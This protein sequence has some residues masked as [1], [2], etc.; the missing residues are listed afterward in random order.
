MTA[1]QPARAVWI[2]ITTSINPLSWIMRHSLRGLCGLKLPYRRR[3]KPLDSSQP[4]RAVWIEIIVSPVS[5]SSPLS[6]P[7]RA[8]WIEIAMLSCWTAGKV[9]HSL[10]GLCG[11]KSCIK[12]PDH[13]P[14]CHSL[15]GLCGLKFPFRL[16]FLRLS[17]SQPARAVWIEID[18]RYPP[19]VLARVTACEGCVD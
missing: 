14:V 2:E 3:I 16:P 17:R 5:Y 15:R 12:S 13:A 6:Q 18:R 7:A 4:A 1:S 10:R 19:P 11:L 9:G 8:V